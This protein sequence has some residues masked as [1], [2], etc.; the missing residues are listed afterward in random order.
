MGYR[1]D[2][3]GEAHI[4]N[5]LVDI[6]DTTGILALDTALLQVVP[7]G[8]LGNTLD[9]SLDA[10]VL[11]T[12]APHAENPDQ[13]LIA[14][15]KT[16][17]GVTDPVPGKVTGKDGGF[18]AENFH[19]HNL[20]GHSN[21]TRLD[22]AALIDTVHTGS[23]RIQ[24]ENLAFAQHGL[25]AA[26]N[27]AA[28]FGVDTTHDEVN[29]SAEHVAKNLILAQ[30]KVGI[31][32]TGRAAAQIDHHFLDRDNNTE[33]LVIHNCHRLAVVQ[34]FNAAQLAG[35]DLAGAVGIMDFMPDYIITVFGSLDIIPAADGKDG[36]LA[37]LGAGLTPGRR[38]SGGR[39]G[40]FLH[41]RNIRLHSRF[42]RIKNSVGCIRRL[43]C[44][45]R[46]FLCDSFFRSSGFFLLS[47]GTLGL[48]RCRGFLHSV[49]VIFVNIRRLHIRVFRHISGSSALIV[50]FSRRIPEHFLL[51]EFRKG[52]FSHIFGRGVLLGLIH[53]PQQFV[54]I[55]TIASVSRKGFRLSGIGQQ[56]F[57]F[58]HNGFGN[59]S[60]LFQK[61]FFLGCHRLKPPMNLIVLFKT[62]WNPC[63]W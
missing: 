40:S 59:R 34:L 49:G 44:F 38:R 29:V 15:G 6:C 5:A 16:L 30:H 4:D 19:A 24:I 2:A 32:L 58:R 28:G 11:Q 54:Q 21:H 43:C 52:I 31:F 1:I 23:I 20:F 35:D 22:D 55:Q 39:S 41:D 60:V 25:L 26:G 61:F 9:V 62:G 36:D 56:S 13:H 37:A 7:V 63:L 57:A 42:L 18:N 51:G 45:G 50:C 12:V 47:A 8:V 14:Y 17:M 3:V 27:Y 33:P 48:G 10:Q 46:N 53:L